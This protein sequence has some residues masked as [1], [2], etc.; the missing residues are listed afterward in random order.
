MIPDNHISRV[1]NPNPT[2]HDS[3]ILEQTQILSP[4]IEQ[5]NNEV[6][7]PPSQ[8]HQIEQAGR[9][10]EDTK[11]EPSSIQLEIGSQK[12]IYEKEHG[13]INT[14]NIENAASRIY[15]SL[16]HIPYETIFTHLSRDRTPT[17]GN[18]SEASDKNKNQPVCSVCG[19]M[20]AINE[21]LSS[22][23]AKKYYCNACYHQKYPFL[24]NAGAK[25]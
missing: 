22:L 3:K 14:A 9:L 13:C 19:A 6:H 24:S 23:G 1:E 20:P 10:H 7:V 25:P 12:K 18:E 17:N 16:R 2:N 15:E 8:Q 11:N 4:V 5:S 21:S